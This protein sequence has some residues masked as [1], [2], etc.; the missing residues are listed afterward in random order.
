MIESSYQLLD[1][2]LQRFFARL[3]VFR[4]GWTL[5]AAEAIC[6]QPW[7][8][9]YLASSS[10]AAAFSAGGDGGRRAPETIRPRG[11]SKA[12][13]IRMDCTQSGI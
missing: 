3:S 1:P 13:S 2:E 6:Q 11:P 5:D 4:G 10:R 8:L 12:L 9:D 7:A